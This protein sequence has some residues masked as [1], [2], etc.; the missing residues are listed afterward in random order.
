MHYVYLYRNGAGK[1]LYAGY[2]KSL[3]RPLSHVAASHCRALQDYVRNSN[4]RF[5]VTVAGPFESELTARAVE[6][7][8]ISALSPQFNIAGGHKAHRFRPFGVPEQYVERL[9]QPPLERRD[10]ISIQRAP[11]SVLF[12]RISE[13]QFDDGRIAY[14]PSAPPDDVH[15]LERVDRWWQLEGCLASWAST[16]TRSPRLLIGVYGPPGRQII[17]ASVRIDRSA[18]G[19]VEHFPSGE[20]KVKIPT[21]G[22]DNLDAFRLRGRRIATGQVRFGRVPSQFFALLQTNGRVRG[23]A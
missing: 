23:G 17:I 21:A 1:A 10:F 20:G 8:V 13:R 11:G 3:M 14:D 12:V 9:A 6:T 22:P 7:A 4:N 16:P 5:S 18:W 2:G 19:R 15:V